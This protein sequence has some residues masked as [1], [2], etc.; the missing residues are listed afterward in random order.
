[1]MISGGKIKNIDDS[2]GVSTTCFAINTSDQIVGLYT[3]TSGNPHGFEYTSGKFK[4]IPGPSGSIAS[5][6]FGINDSGT[7]SGLYVDGDRSPP[8]FR[9]H[10]HANTK[11]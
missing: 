2:K 6:A 1:M 8:R 11:P 5:A 4:D 10:W 3:D 9:A 7:I